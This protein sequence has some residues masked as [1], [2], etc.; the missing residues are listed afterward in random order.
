MSNLGILI[1][2]ISL[3]SIILVII[4]NKWTKVVFINYY[5]YLI[6]SILYLTYFILF[7][8]VRDIQFFKENDIN[9]FIEYDPYTYSFRTSKIFLL[10]LC[11]MISM[12][13]PISLIFDK[14]R[15]TSKVLS[16]YGF[17]GGALTIFGNLIF[18]NDVDIPIWKFIF[19]GDD[20]NYLMFSSHY[21]VM[22][23][24][25]IV[26]LNS[27]KF[28]KWSILGTLIFI[29]LFILY[30][31]IISN[32]F[33]IECNT[34]G[35]KK[36]DWIKPDNVRNWYCEY[37]FLQNILNLTYPF[38]TIFWY[39]V[40]MLIVFAIIILRNLLI[41]DKYYIETKLWWNKLYLIDNKVNKLLSNI[42]DK[43]TK[44]KFIYK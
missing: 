20:P 8:Y 22:I 42:D 1:L 9:F 5:F 29:V 43:F 17:L 3:F 4:F 15:N 19:I 38:N 21:I 26:I 12:L 32:L 39:S 18:T 2:L 16:L 34:T 31:T 28:T 30:I 14:T 35:L 6:I 13:L 40:A 10:D 27:K 23:L 25:L 36:G 7:R 11:P 24:S 44:K 41:K 37:G 33:N